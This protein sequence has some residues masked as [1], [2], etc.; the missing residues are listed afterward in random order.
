MCSAGAMQEVIY[1]DVTYMYA[2]IGSGILSSEVAMNEFVWI[3][4][5]DASDANAK[6][7]N[8]HRLKYNKEPEDSGLVSCSLSAFWTQIFCLIDSLFVMYT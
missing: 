6:Q 3:G 1:C 8:I 4:R 5:N 2:S 7:Q